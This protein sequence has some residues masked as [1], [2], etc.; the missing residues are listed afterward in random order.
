MKASTH[1]PLWM[2]P[3][4]MVSAPGRAAD[5]RSAADYFTFRIPSLVDA[6]ATFVGACCGSTPGLIRALAETLAARHDAR[7]AY[8]GH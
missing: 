3:N 5:G 1:L 7:H 8:Q 4:V 6:G 2:K